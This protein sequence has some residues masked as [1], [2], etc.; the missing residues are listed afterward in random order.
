MYDEEVQ[1]PHSRLEA[2]IQIV[3]AAIGK[4]EE[5][6]LK[7]SVCLS[8][9]EGWPRILHRMDGALYPTAELARDKA[10]TAAA[11]RMPSADITGFG[12]KSLPGL[13]IPTSGW[14]ERFCPVPGGLPILK[15]SDAPAYAVGVCGG[16]PSQDVRIAKAAVKAAGSI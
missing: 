4:A 11:F 12:V 16:S 2:Y 14:N 5:L 9:A 7:V 10:W 1:A 15:G 6:G 3:D 13:G 8:D